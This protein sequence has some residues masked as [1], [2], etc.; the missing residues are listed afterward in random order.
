MIPKIQPYKLCSIKFIAFL[1]VLGLLT[2]AT[3]IVFTSSFAKLSGDNVVKIIE[4]YFVHVI[5]IFGG[6]L[7][8]NI[9]SKLFK[10]KTIEGKLIGEKTMSPEFEAQILGQLQVMQTNIDKMDATISAQGEKIDELILASAQKNAADATKIL[11]C[12]DRF[13]NRYVMERDFDTLLR[14]YFDKELRRRQGIWSMIKD[15]VY[16]ANIVA[17]SILVFKPLIIGILNNI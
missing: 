5:H 12:E 11:S 6:F 1:F 13:D 9:S 15:I 3:A 4:I 16:I 7:V 17:L 8:G 14:R 2:T 10:K